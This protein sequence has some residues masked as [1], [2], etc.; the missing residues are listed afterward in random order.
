MELTKPARIF[1]NNGKRIRQEFAD[2]FNSQ[3]PVPIAGCTRL[4]VESVLIEYNPQYPNFA[5][6][7]SNLELFPSDLGSS[8]TLSVPNEVDWTVYTV[9]GQSS[10]PKNFQ[11][12]INAELSTAGSAAVVTLADATSS[13]YPG[14]MSWAVAGANLTLLGQ[15]ALNNPERSIMERLGLSLRYADTIPELT[16]TASRTT[17]TLT[18]GAPVVVSPGNYMLGR[19]GAVYLL[20]DLDNGAQSDSNIQNIM[21]VLPI[22]AGI[23][24]GDIVEGEDTNSLTTAVNPASDFNRI[25]TILLDDNYQPFELREEA[26]VIIEYH[27]GY[28]KADEVILG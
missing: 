3:L 10:W 4:T 16:F 19:T 12:Y 2:Q 9:N 14:Y 26:K 22:R 17:F 28:T 7:V 6:Y 5:P 13:G 18:A 25:Q 20:S 11:E 21:S 24:L 15:S 23:G 8:F 27:A 1:I